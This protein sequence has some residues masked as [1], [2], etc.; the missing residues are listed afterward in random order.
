MNPIT[1][2]VQSFDFSGPTVADLV[3][4]IKTELFPNISRNQ[5]RALQ[6]AIDAE[7]ETNE[8]AARV[9]AGREDL[10]ERG[11]A[12][13]YAGV[14]PY[15]KEYHRALANLFLAVAS[16]ADDRGLRDRALNFRDMG[17]FFIFA[18]MQH[19]AETDRLVAEVTAD[20]PDISSELYGGGE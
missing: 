5:R 7:I 2:A 11:F 4:A 17:D 1:M 15:L 20:W 16:A 19:L 6:Q 8:R 12:T 14:E 18:Y 9:L 10:I 13:G 3:R